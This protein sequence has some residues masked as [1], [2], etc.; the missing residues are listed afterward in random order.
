MKRYTK[1]IKKIDSTQ[2]IPPIEYIL[3]GGA[4]NSKIFIKKVLINP[5]LGESK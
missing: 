2:M 4:D 5:T 3:K 1:G